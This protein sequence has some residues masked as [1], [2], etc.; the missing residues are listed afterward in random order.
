[1]QRVI[2]LFI[3]IY[4]LASPVIII[5]QDP[6]DLFEYPIPSSISEKVDRFDELLPFQSLIDSLNSELSRWAESVFYGEQ[7]TNYSKAQQVISVKAEAFCRAASL[8]DLTHFVTEET[9]STIRS[10]GNDEAGQRAMAKQILESYKGGDKDA[11][12]VL[13][14]CLTRLNRLIPTE[15]T[16]QANLPLI[17]ENEANDFCEVEYFWSKLVFELFTIYANDPANQWIND[18][19]KSHILKQYDFTKPS[20]PSDLK[21]LVDTE[22]ETNLILAYIYGTRRYYELVGDFTTHDEALPDQLNLICEVLTYMNLRDFGSKVER[23]KYG[24]NEEKTLSRVRKF[25][26]ERF[27]DNNKLDEYFYFAAISDAMAPALVSYFK[28]GSPFLS[29][30][31]PVARLAE[32]KLKE[33]CQER[34]VEMQNFAQFSI[35]LFYTEEEKKQQEK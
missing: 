32:Q 26:R 19:L 33:T 22:S 8:V 2:F 17:F 3:A 34:F 6:P 20:F 4:L 30:D 21:G 18:K 27:V 28:D 16:P 24:F 25:M 13:Y 12:A 14:F 23:L 29:G 35:V 31:S 11:L 5:A 1:M 9:I 15:S 10:S 7:I